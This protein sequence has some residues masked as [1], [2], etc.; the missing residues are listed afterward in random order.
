VQDLFIQGIMPPQ[1]Q[2]VCSRLY[3]EMRASDQIEITVALYDKLGG[4]AGMLKDYLVHEMF[5][6]SLARA[7]ALLAVDHSVFAGAGPSMPLRSVVDLG[8]GVGIP[9]AFCTA[10]PCSSEEQLLGV[11]EAWLFLMLGMLVQDTA[12]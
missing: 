7:E 1:L 9:R 11:E 12:D 5:V 3:D 6:R 2:L 10:F 8:F 4:A